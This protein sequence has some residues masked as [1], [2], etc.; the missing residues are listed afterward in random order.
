VVAG[1]VALALGALLLVDERANEPAQSSAVPIA[2]TSSIGAADT[3]ATSATDTMRP[4]FQRADEP[5]YEDT[6]QA[7][8][9]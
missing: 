2:A 3:N 6:V 4:K 9:G 5:E 1:L 8:G 7:H